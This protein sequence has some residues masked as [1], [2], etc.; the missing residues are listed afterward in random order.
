MT[1]GSASSADVGRAQHE[2]SGRIPGLDGLR[3]ISISLVILA[4]ST[5]LVPNWLTAY[6]PFT[7]GK[8]Y[9]QLGVAVF[10]VISG[11]LITTLLIQERTGTGGISLPNFYRRRTLRI[12]P[13]YF[14]FL[15][16]TAALAAWG[17]QSIPLHEVLYAA[18]FLT[19]Y[20]RHAGHSIGRTW[21]L[22]VE[23]QFYLCWPLIVLT[24]NRKQ[25]LTV[26]AVVI[27][28]CPVVRTLTYVFFP[29]LRD[30]IPM[31]FHTRADSLVFGCAAALLYDGGHLA[32]VMP[33]IHRWRADLLAL[34]YLLVIAPAIWS[35]LHGVYLLPLGYSLEGFAAAILLL[36]A[37]ENRTGRLG[38]VLNQPILVSIGVLSYSLYLWHFAFA[39]PLDPAWLDIPAITVPL[40]FAAALISYRWIEIPFRSLRGRFRRAAPT[41]LV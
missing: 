7:Q 21:S 24:L 40:S 1:V 17:I 38:P 28:F 22:S 2:G 33:L 16:V 32:R 36:S 39:G 41:G 25:L 12:F 11:F 5:R 19:D 37:I 35:R 14:V 9:G 20:T 3:A 31:M 6:P 15:A 10:F 4:H 29:G 13:A 8:F 30:M 34:C 18:L 23:E 27:A 26:C